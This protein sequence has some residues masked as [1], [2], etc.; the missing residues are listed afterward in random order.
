MQNRSPLFVTRAMLDIGAQALEHCRTVG[1]ND[2]TTAHVVFSAML[3]ETSWS[4]AIRT[5]PGYAKVVAPFSAADQY[6]NG[7]KLP[8]HPLRREL[9]NSEGYRIIGH[10]PDGTPV[11]QLLRNIWYLNP[12]YTD[13]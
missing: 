6:L 7:R 8:K 4:P 1:H 11:K 12:P 5:R 10:M 3:S 9:F 13:S 2:A